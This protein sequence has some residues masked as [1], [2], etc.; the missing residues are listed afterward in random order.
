LVLVCMCTGRCVSCVSVCDLPVYPYEKGHIFLSFPRGGKDTYRQGWVA[1]LEEEGK[2]EKRRRKESVCVWSVEPFPPPLLPLAPGCNLQS[3]S[4][5]QKK[6][7]N[8]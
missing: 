8:E 5:S 4:Q 1:C 7:K 3:R 2:E 6:E